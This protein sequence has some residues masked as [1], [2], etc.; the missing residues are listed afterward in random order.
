MDGKE[1][2]LAARWTRRNCEP[3]LVKRLQRLGLVVVDG[4]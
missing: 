3:T 1:T 4:E 2:R